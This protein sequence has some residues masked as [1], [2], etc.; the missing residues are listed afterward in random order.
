MIAS[1]LN[2]GVYKLRTFKYR[3]EFQ[4]IWKDTA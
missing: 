2:A 3:N 4:S 1:K